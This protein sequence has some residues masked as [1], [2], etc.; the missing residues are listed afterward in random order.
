[1]LDFIY[2]GKTLKIILWSI[3]NMFFRSGQIL[4]FFIWLMLI[5]FQDLFHNPKWRHL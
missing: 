5:G 1:M 4:Y 3:G 2:R